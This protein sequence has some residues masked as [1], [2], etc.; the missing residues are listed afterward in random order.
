MRHYETIF[1]ITPELT[2]EDTAPVVEKFS[3]ILTD[4]GAALAKVEHWGRRRLAY[5]VKKFNKGYYVLFEYGADPEAVLEMERNF[6]IDDHVIRFLTVKKADVFDPEAV[7]TPQEHSEPEE[8]EAEAAQ[9]EEDAPS[10]EPQEADG[11]TGTD[12]AQDEDTPD[13]SEKQ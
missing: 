12:E 10:D 8:P 11:E 9:T 6:K 1:I 13:A 5:T 7:T 3:G 2:E 4:A